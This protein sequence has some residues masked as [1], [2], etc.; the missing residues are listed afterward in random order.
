MVDLNQAAAGPLHPEGSE[1]RVIADER[2]L[3]GKTRAARVSPPGDPPGPMPWCGLGLSGGG[4]SLGIAQ[5]RRS[6]GASRKG[7]PQ[8]FRLHFERI[9]GRLY[10]NR[11]AMVVGP[12]TG[13]PA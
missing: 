1:A 7:H 12:S 4:I 5:P 6:A 3:I 9:G 10:R 2:A 11:A 8:A 13:R